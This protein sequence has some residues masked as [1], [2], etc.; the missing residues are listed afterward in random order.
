M[1]SGLV[2]SGSPRKRG[3]EERSGGGPRFRGVKSC[4]AFLRETSGSMQ[5]RGDLCR[6]GDQVA[7]EV[8]DPA[9]EAAGGTGD[10]ESG[11]DVAAHPSYRDGDTGE[12]VLELVHG[13][14][15]PA[16]SGRGAV[17]LER[18]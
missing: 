12:P 15:E 14:R 4:H 6:P 5:H 17:A 1:S 8:L 7:A 11:D 3:P 10:A 18:S 13:H 9:V 16:P 2:I